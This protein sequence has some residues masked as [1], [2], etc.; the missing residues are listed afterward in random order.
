MTQHGNTPPP[1]LHP[2]AT[3]PPPDHYRPARL[4]PFSASPLLV[5]QSRGHDTTVAS[6]KQVWNVYNVRRLVGL[7]LVR[8][9]SALF[10]H[11]RY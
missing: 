5:S 11:L 2:H 1:L 8:F 7:P 9:R 3:R 10:E 4:P 6:S